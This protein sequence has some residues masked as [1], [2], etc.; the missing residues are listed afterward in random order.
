MDDG[1]MQKYAAL[2]EQTR[3][4]STLPNRISHDPIGTG[5]TAEGICRVPPVRLQASLKE[6]REEL[7][8]Y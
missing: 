7:R 8:A 2:T 6:T 3:A 4:A 5:G 1:C